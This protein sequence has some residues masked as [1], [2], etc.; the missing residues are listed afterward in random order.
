MPVL[1]PPGDRAELSWSGWGDPAHAAPLP[2]GLDQFVRDGLGVSLQTPPPPT[3]DDLELT[4]VRLPEPVAERLTSIVGDANVRFDHEAR[5]R[6][7]LG[8]S[9]LDLLAI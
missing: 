1:R 8:K 7:A 3:I 2:A 9:T 6:H 5:A 4:P